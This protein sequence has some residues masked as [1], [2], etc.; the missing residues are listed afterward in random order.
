METTINRFSKSV[1]DL[2]EKTEYIGASNKWVLLNNYL[3]SLKE[4]TNCKRNKSHSHIGL[5]MGRIETDERNVERIFAG[6]KQWIT[7]IYLPNQPLFKVSLTML[8]R[9]L[10]V[11]KIFVMIF[12]RSS[13]GFVNFDDR[14][15]NHKEYF[16]SIRKQPLLTFQDNVKKLKVQIFP[17]RRNFFPR[18]S[19]TLCQ[20]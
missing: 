4:H 8:N 10:L 14:S 3:C 13:S 18:N 7:N 5:G 16:D 6:L 15:G 11:K 2:S 9:L 20:E 19:D 12:L 17:R 1:G